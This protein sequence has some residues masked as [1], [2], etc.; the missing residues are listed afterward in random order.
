MPQDL[1]VDIDIDVSEV[2]A[3]LNNMAI[4]CKEARK[5]FRRAYAK[6]VNRV[7]RAVIAGAK[8][9]TSNREK[10]TKGLTTTLW[11]GGNGGAIRIWR[12]NYLPSTGKYF[13]LFWLDRGTS[14][15]IGRNGRKHGATPPHPFFEQAVRSSVPQA[16]AD[17]ERNILAELEKA[18]NKR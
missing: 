17:L 16:V 11:K 1:F 15:V 9:V 14:E 5:S 18:Y 6:A 12:G 10:A 3:S 13:A 2:T 7:K 8:T 4:T